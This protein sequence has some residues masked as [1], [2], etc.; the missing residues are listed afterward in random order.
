[1][2][3]L[4][5]RREL[6][7]GDVGPDVTVMR[8]I[9]GLPP[10]AL[11]DDAMQCV[12]GVQRVSGLPESGLVDEATAKAIGESASA[13]LAPA[14]FERDIQLW[15]QGE[16]VRAV[17][18]LLGLGS[19]DDRYD[20]DAESIVRRIQSANGITPTGILGFEEARIIGDV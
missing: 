20:P 16:D 19:R 13:D 9:L 4:W 14:W 15:C 2:T 7:E 5:F 17:R 3:P 1:V 10:G 11:D 6:S 18:A 12:R 8:R